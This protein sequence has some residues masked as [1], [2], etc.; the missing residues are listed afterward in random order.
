MKRIIWV[1]CALAV[2][3]L[4]GSRALALLYTPS[5]P[6]AGLAEETVKGI[7]PGRNYIASSTLDLQVFN[8]TGPG[9]AFS[10]GFYSYQAFNGYGSPGL[11]GGWVHDYDEYLVGAPD[12]T[13]DMGLNYPNGCSETLTDNNG[14]LSGPADAPY[15][16]ANDAGAITITWQNGTKWTFTPGPP[17]RQPHRVSRPRL[18][19]RRRE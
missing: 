12:A 8:P 17:G 1:A 7:I 18:H 16:V 3:A 10:R 19:L 6:Y 11:P 13:G 15:S 5:P 4:S 2:L 9:V 14:A